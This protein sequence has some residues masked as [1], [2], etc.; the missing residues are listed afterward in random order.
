MVVNQV[1][2]TLNDIFGEI[3]GEDNL[4][5]EDLSNFID[6]GRS[7]TSSTEWSDNFDHYVGKLIDR[8]GKTIIVDKKYKSQGID[9]VVDNFEY[10]SILQKIRVSVPDFTD[11]DA[12]SLQPGESYDYTTYSPVDMSAKYYNKKYTFGVEWSW[13]PIVLKESMD[14]LPKL[15]AL[16]AAIENRIMVKVRVTTDELTYRAVNALNGENI[17]SGKNVINLLELYMNE[18]E[19][20]TINSATALT[21]PEFL[22]HSVVTLKKYT[23][24]ISRISKKF[25]QD[26]ELNWT[27]DD[28]LRIVALTDYA[29]ALDAYL[30]SSTYHDEF[31]KFNG[32]TSIAAW[33]GLGDLS[34]DLRSSININLVSD[35]TT[36][37][38]YSGI[39]CTMFDKEGCC[40]CNETP[41]VE[42][43][44][45]N[46]KGKFTNYYYTYDASM[47]VDT[48]ENCITFVISDYAI[49]HEEP[50]DWGVGTYYNLV[51]GEYT[52]VAANVDF[53]D[54][55]VVYKKITFDND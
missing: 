53:D 45:Y 9:I 21:N 11:N 5:T 2:E 48:A 55:G 6:V 16:Y 19:D 32:F 41:L 33:Q 28:N 12:W 39:V 50:D 51:D 25:N 14:S 36:S 22:R 42:T 3:I 13:T 27:Q 44:P 1:A 4:F 30:Y 10:G 47:F 35:P 46:P 24:F 15:L 26:G 38:E 54:A 43:A 31:V 17:N 18:T 29:A 7:I 23:K 52:E 40:I 34:F 49:V 20:N 37:I 8:I